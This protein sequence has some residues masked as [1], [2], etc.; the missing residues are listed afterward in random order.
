MARKTTVQVGQIVG[1][2]GIRGHV[3]VEPLTQYLERLEAG[4][5]LKLGDQWLTVENCTIHKGRPLLKL[6]GVNTM[7]EAQALQWKYLEAHAEKPALEEDEFLTEDLIGLDVFTVEGEPLGRVDDVLAMPAHDVLQV[8]EILI[9]AVKEFVK[10]IDLD[11]GRVTVQLIY[12]M[13]PGETD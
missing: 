7:S 12:G 13:R 10:D 3:K 11:E 8:G 1:A 6:S 4:R 5:Q 2:F 9:P